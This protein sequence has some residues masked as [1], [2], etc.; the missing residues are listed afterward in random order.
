MRIEFDI[1][2]IRAIQFGVGRK[3]GDSVQYSI[4]AADNDVQDAL[5]EEAQ[6]MLGRIMQETRTP[7]PYDPA[8]KYGNDEYLVLPLDD[9]LSTSLAEFHRAANLSLSTPELKLLKTALSYFMRGTDKSGRRLTA[10]N[11]AAQFKATLGRQGRLMLASNTLRV[12]PD[13]VVQLNAGFDII[14][15]SEQVHIFRPASFRSLGNV[16]EAIA[17][18]VP[19]NVEAI[20]KAAGFVQWTNIEEYATGRPRAASLLASIR[21]QKYADNLDKEGLIALCERTGVVLDTSQGLISVADNQIIPFLE[22][23]D[24]RRFEI[25][26]V[27]NAP[28]QYKASSRTRI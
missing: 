16:D 11:R 18:A 23:I 27:P 13:P 6:S 5:R 12:I 24:R 20:S 3:E 19:R 14:I 9:E 28:E 21:T 25:E 8:E 17:Q 4:L 22:V 2:Q 26:L 1:S 7:Q 15:D 10:L